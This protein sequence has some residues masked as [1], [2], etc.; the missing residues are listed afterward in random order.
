ME[1]PKSWM[2][3]FM[4]NPNLKWMTRGNPR[5]HGKPPLDPISGGSAGG[6]ETQGSNVPRCS[7]HPGWLVTFR[8]A[9]DCNKDLKASGKP[10]LGGIGPMLPVYLTA[11]WYGFFPVSVDV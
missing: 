4:E 9:P 6:R 11:A 8:S 3:Y 5:H 1:V 10:N 7:K 2:V